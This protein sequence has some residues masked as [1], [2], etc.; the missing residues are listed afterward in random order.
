MKT[1]RKTLFLSFTFAA[2]LAGFVASSTPSHAKYLCG[3][4]PRGTVCNWTP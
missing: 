1:F 3:W 4:T 2:M